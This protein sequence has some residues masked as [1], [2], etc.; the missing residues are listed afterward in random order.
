M[1]TL[2]NSIREKAPQSNAGQFQETREGY[3]TI[4]ACH[5][6]AALHLHCE[7]DKCESREQARKE[8]QGE[9][10]FPEFL[11]HTEHRALLKVTVR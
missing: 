3:K 2:F 4:Q 8:N 7:A 6:Q 10:L 11:F 1:K 5:V 9:R